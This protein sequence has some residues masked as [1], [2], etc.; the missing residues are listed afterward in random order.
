MD[1]KTGW[2][3]TLEDGGMSEQLGFAHYFQT[4]MELT[5]IYCMF[6]H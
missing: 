1:N 5:K 6:S 4:H 3:N 2:K